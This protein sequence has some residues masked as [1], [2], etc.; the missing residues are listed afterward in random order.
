ML[1]GSRPVQMEYDLSNLF[2]RE[3]FKAVIASH[4]PVYLDIEK[5]R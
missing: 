1:G 4:I 5:A 2:F 3:I